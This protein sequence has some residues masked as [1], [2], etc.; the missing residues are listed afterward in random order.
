MSVPNLTLASRYDNEH[1]AFNVENEFGETA[2]NYAPTIP[3]SNGESAVPQQYIEVSRNLDNLSN[4]LADINTPRNFQLFAGQ[5]GTC[6]FLMVAIIGGENYA[7]SVKIP[8]ND[9]IVYGRRWLIEESTPTSEII[10]TAMLSV[11]KAREHEIRELLTLSINQGQQITTPFNCHLDLPLMVGNRSD[12]TSGQ[13]M[14]VKEQ[15]NNVRLAG[16]E[17]NLVR[18]IELGDK[19]IVEVALKENQAE[20]H[21]EELE[22]AILTVVCEHADGADFLHQLISTLIKHSDRFVEEHVTFKDF[23]RFSHDIDVHKLGE[24]SYKTRNL[25]IVDSRFN[26][27]FKDMSYRVDAAKAPEYNSGKLGQQQRQRLSEYD[28]LAGYLPVEP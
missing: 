3:L 21:F 5:E 26:A 18:S 27:E 8:V 17:L 2:L 4:V 20:Y 11:K 10:Q 22:G 12:M 6:L 9:K 7:A 1:R 23:N 15:L 25:E 13:P 28:S 24:F 19:L 14:K 16:N